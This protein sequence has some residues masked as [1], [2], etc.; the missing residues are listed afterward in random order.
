MD[1]EI[2]KNLN[3]AQPPSGIEGT[4]K[5]FND[6]HEVQARF[7]RAVSDFQENIQN[8]LKRA[9]EAHNEMEQKLRR[10][11]DVDFSFM[12]PVL[13]DL[14]QYGWYLNLGMTITDVAAVKRVLASGDENQLNQCMVLLLKEELAGDVG[15]LCGKHSNRSDA[16]EQA[17]K[18]HEAGLY[19]ASMPVI[20]A[21]IDGLSYELTGYKFFDNDRRT[22]EPEIAK[23]VA[24]NASTSSLE[25][26]Y[27]SVLLDKG[28]FQKHRNNPNRISFTRHSILHG[29]TTDYGTEIN[30]L[31]AFSL[32]LFLSDMCTP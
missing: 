2:K 21:Q 8:T 25:S 28:A 14:S 31:K 11:L 13:Q 7:S 4:L 12:A 3:L 24:E 5:Y 16:I 17:F 27:L 30:S 22:Y 18:A 10:A 32:L 1:D 23:W 26:A 9:L 15:R 20:F 19:Y 29:E 6:L